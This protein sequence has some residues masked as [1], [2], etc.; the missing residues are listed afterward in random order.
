[1]AAR[2]LLYA[3][4][5]CRFRLHLAHDFLPPSCPTTFSF[6]GAGRHSTKTIFRKRLARRCL[7]LRHKFPRT[8]ATGVVRSS[9]LLVFP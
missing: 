8:P 7:T 3:L 5:N 4:E 6:S 1:M 2:A 9:L